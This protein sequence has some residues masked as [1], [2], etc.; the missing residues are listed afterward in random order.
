MK[1]L[2]A[3]TKSITKEVIKKLLTGFVGKVMII[4]LSISYYLT[5]KISLQLLIL[6][7]L[8]ICTRLNYHGFTLNL[9]NKSKVRKIT[10]SIQ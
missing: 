3:K 6:M 9:S 5:D 7:L 8:F 2:F 10:N 1:K 4:P